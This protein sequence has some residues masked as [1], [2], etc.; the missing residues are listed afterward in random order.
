[1]AGMM[2]LTRRA[3]ATGGMAAL[4]APFIVRRGAR[5]ASSQITAMNTFPTLAREHWQPWDA[6]ARG[7]CEQLG[8]EYLSQIFSGSVE[9][10]ISQI[11]AAASLGVNAVVTFAQ[12]AEIVKALAITASNRT[13][14]SRTPTPPLCGWIRSIRPTGTATRS[15]RSPTTSA[16]S[17]RCASCCSMRSATTGNCSTS[18]AYPGNFAAAS[19]RAGLAVALA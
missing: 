7:A 9:K 6:G 18:R 11:E 5:A 17:R 14:F 15:T 2:R 13:S 19:R 8:L 16:A 3:M 10:Q 1:M 12:D 4:A